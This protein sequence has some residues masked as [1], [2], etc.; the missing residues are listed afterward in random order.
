MTIDFLISSPD[1]HVSMFRPL[2][3]WLKENTECRLRVLS[4]CEL[5]GFATPVEEIQRAGAEACLCLPT[6]FPKNIRATRASGEKIKARSPEWLRTV[7]WHGLVNWSLFY[8]RERPSLAV[9]PNDC[10]FPNYHIAARLRREAVPFLLVQEGIR[11]E[12][13]WQPSDRQ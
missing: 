8:R 2:L 1:H 6:R 11:F 3:G 5:R 12:Q 4:L 10:A 9:L 7:L 13:P